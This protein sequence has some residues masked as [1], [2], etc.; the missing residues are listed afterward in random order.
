MQQLSLQNL[1]VDVRN[2]NN[3]VLKKLNDYI[4]GLLYLGL[5]VITFRTLSYFGQLLHLG[6]QVTILNFLNHLLHVQNPKLRISNERG[7][8]S[9]FMSTSDVFLLKCLEELDE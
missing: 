3:N 4:D 7:C 2:N 6:L 9:G 8:V 1:N 5:N